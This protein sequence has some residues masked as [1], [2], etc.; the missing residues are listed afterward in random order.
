MEREKGG[1]WTAEAL[2]GALCGHLE[3][4]D[5]EGRVLFRPEGADRPFPVAIGFSVSDGELVRSARLGRRALVLRAAGEPPRYVLAGFVRERVSARARDAREPQVEASVDGETVTVAG[6]RK[7]EIS[8]GKS[9]IV[10][11]ADGRVEISGSYLLTR[12]RGPLKIKGAVVDI[13]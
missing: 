6:R 1:I 12:S 13:N 7:V 11:H 4:V 8:C 3:G 10:L 2:E 9:R 5:G